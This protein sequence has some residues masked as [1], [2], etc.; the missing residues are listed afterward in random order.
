MMMMMMMMP[1]E[2]NNKDHDDRDELYTFLLL[3]APIK[4]ELSTYPV[5]MPLATDASHNA[6]KLHEST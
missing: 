5:S 4:R 1:T 6:I 2:D 3:N